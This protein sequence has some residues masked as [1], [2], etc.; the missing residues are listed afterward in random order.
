MK[1]IIFNIFFSLAI[2]ILAINQ[3][4]AKQYPVLYRD[5]EVTGRGGTMVA[6]GGSATSV[7]YNPAGLAFLNPKEGFEVRLLDLSLTLSKKDVDFG[8][9]IKDVLDSDETDDE[10][11]QDISDIFSDYLGDTF[12]LETNNMVFSLAKRHSSFAWGFGIFDHLDASGVVHQGFGTAGVL[13]VDAF[14][15]AGVFLGFSFPAI[16]VVNHFISNNSTHKR[17][18]KIENTFWIGFDIKGV[19]VGSF[20]HNVLP[21]ELVNYIDNSTYWDD[22]VYDNVVITG[23]VGFMLEPFPNNFWDPMMGFSIMNIN[24]IKAKNDDGETKT[25][26]P[27]TYNLGFAIRPKISSLFSKDSFAYH[28][29]FKD[30][31]LALDIQDLSK[32]Y[33][34]SDWGKRLY[35]GGSIKLF[36]SRPFSFG[37]S[38]GFYQ[39]YPSY[40]VHLTFFILRADFVCY[41]EEIGSYAGQKE[42]KRYLFSLSIRW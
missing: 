17:L 36:K 13:S 12:Y 1:K 16:K 19:W 20:E 30:A 32:A 6:V 4:K 39:G 29:L 21:V 27:R 42:D 40:G 10:K 24:P 2:F 28:Y 41:S 11:I 9:D 7:F 18:Q 8:Q 23:D 25:L 26:I 5:I 34:D 33:S 31:V 22:F 37:I 35:L 3:A 14:G 15:S 38:G